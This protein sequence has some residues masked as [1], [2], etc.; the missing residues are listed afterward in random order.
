MLC[1]ISSH[2][3][4]EEFSMT[5]NALLDDDLKDDN[6]LIQELLFGPLPTK[7]FEQKK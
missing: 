2:F 7:T 1:V 3:N 6:I 4:R 5:I